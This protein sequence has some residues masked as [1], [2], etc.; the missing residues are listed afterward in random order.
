M[1]KTLVLLF[2]ALLIPLAPA[3]QGG[4]ANSGGSTLV[5]SGVIINST[6]ASPAGALSVNCPATTA[7]ACAGGSFS[8]ISNDGTTTINATFT[9]GTYPET[10]SGGGKG[11]KIVCT[12]SF[13]GLFTGTVG[14]THQSFGTGGAAAT[15]TTGYN[16]AY[17]PFYFT[18]GNAR[19]LRSDDLSGTNAIAYGTQGTGVGQFYGPSGIALD[20]AGRIYITDTLQ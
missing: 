14:V 3:D 19:I 8:Y 10:C 7:G 9:S 13:T 12:Y 6:V 18:D 5:S 20:S 17:T 2:F 11:G 1:N 4:L 16:S 15:G